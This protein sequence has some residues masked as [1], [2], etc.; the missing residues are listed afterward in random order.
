M[1]TPDGFLLLFVCFFGNPNIDTYYV[2]DMN[3]THG[4]LPRQQI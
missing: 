3:I 4:S 2:D 1:G